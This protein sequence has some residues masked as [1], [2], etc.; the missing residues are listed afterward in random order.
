MGMSGH[1]SASPLRACVNVDDCCDP[2]SVGTL[3]YVKMIETY[4]KSVLPPY[5][6]DLQ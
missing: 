3:T 2:F 5:L 4:V 6:N 1:V